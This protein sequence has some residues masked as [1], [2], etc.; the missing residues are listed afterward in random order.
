MDE[1][2]EKIVNPLEI[3]KSNDEKGATFTEGSVL[4]DSGEHLSEAFSTTK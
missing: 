4:G 1:L 3:K 2:I